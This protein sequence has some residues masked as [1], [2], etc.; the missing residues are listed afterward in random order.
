MEALNSPGACQPLSLITPFQECLMLLVPG[1]HLEGEIRQKKLTVEVFHYVMA[2]VI[3]K[4]CRQV[5]VIICKV[6][7][8][9]LA[10]VLTTKLPRTVI[11][12]KV[13]SGLI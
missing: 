4:D 11:W 12:H 9:Q 7:N 6:C 2:C 5:L 1:M 13:K 10:M 8:L 3:I